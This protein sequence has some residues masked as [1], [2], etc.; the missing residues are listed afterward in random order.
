MTHDLIYIKKIPAD[1]QSTILNTIL[2][3]IKWASLNLPTL[4][5]A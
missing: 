5:L 4:L 3:I 1:T 2:L